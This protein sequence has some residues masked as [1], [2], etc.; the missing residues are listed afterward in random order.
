MAAV[1]ARPPGVELVIAAPT[2]LC[3]GSYV[4]GPRRGDSIAINGC[5]LTLLS[6]EGRAWAFSA[7]AETLSR[8]NLG[9]LRPGD[10]VNLERSL[11]ADGRFGGH[12]VQ[13]H[14]DD[15]GTVDAI[16]RDGEWVTMWFAVP[17]RLSRQTVSKGSVAVDGVSLTVV[18]VAPRRFSVALIPHTLTAT[19]LGLRD[20][21]DVVNVETDV[22]GKYVEKFLA[23]RLGESETAAVDATR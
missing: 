15:V 21:G 22:I 5:C 18:D 19:T 2:E 1:I 7:G 17:E 3:G 9:R 16:D 12:F 8:T 10:V 4:A 13:G 23:A 6:G 11:P 20:V 14:V